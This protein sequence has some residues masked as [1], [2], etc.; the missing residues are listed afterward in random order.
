[1][2]GFEPFRLLV[3]ALELLL[4]GGLALECL[5]RE[6][7]A[8]GTDGLTRLRHEFDDALLELR[9]LQL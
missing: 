2:L 4:Y 7:L 8:S 9:G 6:V 5:P 3:Q 1:M